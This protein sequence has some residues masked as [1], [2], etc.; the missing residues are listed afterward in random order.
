MNSQWVS[1]GK[2]P[3]G[4]LTG[5]LIGCICPGALGLWKGNLQKH[6]LLSR[7][8]LL[9]QRKTPPG[10]KRSLTEVEEMCAEKK[11]IICNQAV[12]LALWLRVFVSW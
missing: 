7:I 12:D 4:L 11:M 8:C 2:K 9:T 3:L 10:V 5:G 6:S 1:F